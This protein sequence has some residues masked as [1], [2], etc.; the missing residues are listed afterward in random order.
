MLHSVLFHVIMFCY[1]IIFVC[2]SLL[3]N[4]NLFPVHFIAQCTL[5]SVLLPWLLDVLALYVY[6]MCIKSTVFQ[7]VSLSLMCS[8][9]TLH[10]CEQ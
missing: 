10:S 7:C 1:F 5:T 3:H 8:G 2:D 6:R 4:N 9:A